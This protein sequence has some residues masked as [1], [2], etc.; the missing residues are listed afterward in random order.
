MYHICGLV[1]MLR[2]FIKVLHWY[3]IHPWSDFGNGN[4][5]N[6]SYDIRHSGSGKFFGEFKLWDNKED[7]IKKFKKLIRSDR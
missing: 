6:T 4:G 1:S 5:D 7:S 3:D 2:A